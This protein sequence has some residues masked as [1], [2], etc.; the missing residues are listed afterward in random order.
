VSAFGGFLAVS[1]REEGFTQLWV[2]AL[3]EGVAAGAHR[4]GFED[5]SFTAELGSNRLFEAAGRLRVEYSSMTSP[6]QPRERAR[7]ARGGAL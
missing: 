6:R 2:V 3:R 5:E 1:G 4:L 7:A